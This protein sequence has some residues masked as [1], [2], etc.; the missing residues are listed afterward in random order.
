MIWAGKKQYQYSGGVFN[1]DKLTNR[2]GLPNLWRRQPMHSSHWSLGPTMAPGTAYQN[3][4]FC[5]VSNSKSNDD[6]RRGY[7]LWP[8]YQWN[9]PSE[10]VE[11][12]ANTLQSLECGSLKA[13]RHCFSEIGNFSMHESEKCKSNA[14][15]ALSLSWHEWGTYLCAGHPM[16]VVRLV[17]ILIRWG[18][19]SPNAAKD[20]HPLNPKIWSGYEANQSMSWNLRQ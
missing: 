6:S 11:R 16:I 9:W 2:I 1:Y 4:K 8:T 3:S 12:P 10:F 19:G 20:S 7:W 17:Y 18:A 5:C 15:R 14:M 13:P